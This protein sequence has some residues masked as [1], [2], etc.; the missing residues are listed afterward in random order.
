MIPHSEIN[1]PMIAHVKPIV[2]SA[3][4]HSGGHKLTCHALGNDRTV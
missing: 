4:R 2:T 1:G 3:L